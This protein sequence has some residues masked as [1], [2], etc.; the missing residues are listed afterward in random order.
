MDPAGTCHLVG[1]P[2]K[3]QHAPHGIGVP[4][5][6]VWL[7]ATRPRPAHR[8]LLID[9]RMLRRAL[10]LLSM[11]DFSMES[12]RGEQEIVTG[13]LHGLLEGARA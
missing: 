13:Y 11:A 7:A 12:T 2:G 10:V 4:S 5:K 1:C 8:D 3:G 6:E 9:E